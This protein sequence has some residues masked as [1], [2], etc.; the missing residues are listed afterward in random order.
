LLALLRAEL[1]R[2]FF[3]DDADLRL[4]GKRRGDHSKLGFGL[5]PVTARYLGTFLADPLDVPSEVLDF[6]AEQLEVAD[7]SRVLEPP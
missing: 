1:E 5:Q 6:V 7:P 4:I 2:F 3:L